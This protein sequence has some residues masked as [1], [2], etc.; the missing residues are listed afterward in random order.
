MNHD[1]IALGHGSG[2]K[3]SRELLEK[4]LL[5]V[6]GNPVLD[7]LEDSA[8]L[9]IA[10]GTRLAF[11]TDSFVVT[12]LFFPG[13]DIG[14]LSVHGTI[15]DLAVSG[16][17]P[18]A[19]SLALIAEEGL[20]T[21]ELRR[22]VES[23]ATACARARVSIVTGD[24]KVVPRGS[25]DKLFVTTSGIGLLRPDRSLGARHVEPGDAVL[26]SGTIAD[27]G[28][29]ILTCRDGLA[30]TT[31]LESD[32]APLHDLSSRLLSDCPGVHAMRDPT[33][34]G[35]AAALVEIAEGRGVGIEIDELRVPI[36]DR[37]RAVCEIYGL[38]PWLIA[39][40]GKLLVF[41]ASEFAERA[42]E[43][44]RRHPLGQRAAV[45]GS[46]T[47]AHPGRVAARTPLGTLRA[48]ALP[49]HELLP[50]IC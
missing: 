44:L 13:G 26:V 3:L 15:N 2:G 1:V 4:L 18:I 10:S 36:D 31:P 34:G 19:L 48:V 41:V 40:E 16:A 17:V 8:S 37:V 33:R 21:G 27:H 24:T 47:S 42:L 22:V 23:I 7:A 46:V 25:A 35:L 45:I 43:T 38:D 32:T 39:N 11:T 49:A 50:R 20:P 5:P 9:S 14:M 28:V 29:A 30:L 12:P 6:L